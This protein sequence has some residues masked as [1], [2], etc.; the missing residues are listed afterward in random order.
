MGNKKQEM[1]NI[2]DIEVVSG[3]IRKI[4]LRKSPVLPFRGIRKLNI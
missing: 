4:P 1:K 2:S 3:G